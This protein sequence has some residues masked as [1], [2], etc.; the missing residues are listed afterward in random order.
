MA[1]LGGDFRGGESI[2][3]IDGHPIVRRGLT[4][5]ITAEPDL[6]VCGQCDNARTALSLVEQLRPGLAII[7][8]A[9]PG[10]SGIALVKQL[11]Q[12]TRVLV[13]SA[14]DELLYAERALTAGAAGFLGKGESV[15]TLLEAIRTVIAGR[16]YAS[17]AVT[18]RMLNRVAGM[19]RTPDAD[20]VTTLSDRELEVFRMIGKG[21]GTRE[22]AAV[23]HLSR[24]TI[25]THRENIKKKLNVRSGNELVVRATA[26]LLDH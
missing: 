10:E 7:D 11:A 3:L 2:L 22:I 19:R 17:R 18:D 16:V 20:S 1:D 21:L 9:L 14:L 26:W 13:F 4:Q 15:E 12:L 23:L 25:E 8:I 5:V 6:S 24:K